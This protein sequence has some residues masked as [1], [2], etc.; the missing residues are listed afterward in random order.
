MT[1]MFRMELT[2]ALLVFAG[3]AASLFLMSLR[4]YTFRR[5]VMIWAGV[6]GLSALLTVALLWLSPAEGFLAG[7]VASLALCAVSLV[8]PH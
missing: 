1:A 3:H 5:S 7:Q 4:R 8:Y 2:S 6:L